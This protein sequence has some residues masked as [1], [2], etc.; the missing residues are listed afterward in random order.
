MTT[1]CRLWQRDGHLPEETVRELATGE[2]MTGQRALD[3]GLLDQVGDYTDALEAAA[4][5]AG[6][7]PRAKL[8]QP[9]RSLSQRL[10]GRP[11]VE[12]ASLT[13]GLQR[14]VSGGVYYLDP[15]YVAGWTSTG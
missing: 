15:A 7:R 6:T 1:S 4:Q 14:L 12:T 13:E 2:V 3:A 10:F 8:L 5:A 9:R 11:A